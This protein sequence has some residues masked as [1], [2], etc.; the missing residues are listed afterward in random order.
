M[1]DV[2]NVQVGQELIKPIIESRIRAA[3][4]AGLGNTEEL[5]RAVIYGVLQLKVDREGR[6]GQ[7]YS[8]DIPMLKYLCEKAIKDTA[9]A[10]VR[11]WIATQQPK[12]KAELV[13]QLD[14][15]KANLAEVMVLGL[16]KAL[17]NAWTFRV[18]VEFK[19]GRD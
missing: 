9:E 17:A 18:D 13:K 12:L 15:H 16:G 19:Q 14:R 8:N 3:V 6:P 11:E 10:A 2:V 1:S 7:G 4:L 5:I